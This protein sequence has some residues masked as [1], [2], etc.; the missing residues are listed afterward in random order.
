MKLGTIIQYLETKYPKTL[1]ED[2]DN[3][4]LQV[5]SLSQDVSTVLISLD[6]TKEVVTEAIENHVDC[7]I[8]HHPLIFKPLKNILFD[9]EVGYVLSTLMK[10]NISLYVMHT[11]YDI[12]SYGMNTV[13][14]SMLG[15]TQ[16]SPLEMTTEHEGSGVVGQ[17]K[18]LD[19]SSFIQL[20]KQTYQV[21]N[22]KMVN[23]SK[24]TISTVAICGGSG[25]DLLLEAVKK[26]ADV[27]ITADVS[28]HTGL[29]AKA[30][31]IMLLDV[32]HHVEE[33]AFKMTKTDLE[34]QFEELSLITS[35]VN[36]NP[37]TFI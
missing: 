33:I 13:L 7:I 15:L 6:V 32:G 1:A 12:S 8:S 17:I 4:G 37:F 20:V 29:S 34:K 14:A 21:D 23:S 24:T 36:P 16:I 18:K 25:G 26:Q 19:T 22:I 11:N 31:D 5:G 27:F 30:Y 10:H 3:V 9:T 28:H 35:S 2:W